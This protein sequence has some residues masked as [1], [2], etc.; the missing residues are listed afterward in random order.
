MLPEIH[1]M[2]KYHFPKH[3]VFL[4]TF[5]SVLYVF[6]LRILLRTLCTLANIP[7]NIILDEPAKLATV[8]S[9]VHLSMVYEEFYTTVR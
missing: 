2:E 6:L 7:H 8:L 4:K 3:I 5:N 9:Y 1:K